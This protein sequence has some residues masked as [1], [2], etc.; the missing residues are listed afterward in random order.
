MSLKTIGIMIEWVEQRL[1]DKPSLD[2]L[3]SHVGYSPYYCSAKFHE[4]VGISY[5]EYVYKRRLSLAADELKNNDC[6][7]LDIAIRYGF[8]SHAA[9]TRAFVKYCGYTPLQYRNLSQEIPSYSRIAIK[10]N[11]FAKKI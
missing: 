7:I 8:S 5:K 1:G 2:E 10:Q 9:F 6:R 3:A 11:S 4:Y